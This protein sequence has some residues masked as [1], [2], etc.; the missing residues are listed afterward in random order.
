MANAISISVRQITIVPDGSTDFDIT[1][2]QSNM[3]ALTAVTGTFTA[4]ETVTQA[5]SGATGVVYSWDAKNQVLYLVS[6]AGVFDATHVVTGG[7]SAAHGI[8]VGIPYGFARGIRLTAVD[9]SPSGTNDILV[10]REGK[11]VGSVIFK[12]T[13]VAGGGVH[14]AVEGKSRRRLPYIVATDCS[15]AVPANAKIILEY[16]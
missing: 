16:D 3:V 12:R 10:I 11:A 15:F 1:T 7:S 5:T 2:V 8:P 4:G 13:D 6:M 14:Q 9:F